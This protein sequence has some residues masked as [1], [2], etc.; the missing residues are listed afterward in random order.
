[1][2]NNDII[3]IACKKQ[4]QLKKLEFTLGICK[5]SKL[6]LTFIRLILD[7][8]SVLCGGC[9][10]AV[11]EKLEKVQLHPARVVSGLPILA[12][13]ESL[14]FETGLDVLAK[15]RET[16]KLTLMYKIYYN[17]LSLYK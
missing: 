10:P 9:S 14:Y 6:Y 12:F 2:F 17:F 15:G 13:T 5:L 16:A 3:N 8:A 4:G 7:D 11:F 1:M